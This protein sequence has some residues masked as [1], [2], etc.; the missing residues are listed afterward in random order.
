M[1]N[2]KEDLYNK[3]RYDRAHSLIFTLHI[4]PTSNFTLWSLGLFNLQFSWAIMYGVLLIHACQLKGNHGFPSPLLVLPSQVPNY[5]FGWR[6][7]IVTELKKT[8]KWQ[9][10]RIAQTRL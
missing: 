8:A 10:K 7:A 6:E 2:N 5:N 3:I 4:H 9:K 1:C